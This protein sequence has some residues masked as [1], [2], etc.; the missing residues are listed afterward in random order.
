METIGQRRL[1][2]FLS[3]Y[4]DLTLP[5]S[6]DPQK[7]SCSQVRKD[8]GVDVSDY[9]DLAQKVATVQYYNP[10]YVFLYRGQAED[11]RRKAA[12]TLKP[13]IFRSPRGHSPGSQDIPS[14][15]ELARRYGVLRQAERLLVL[16]YPHHDGRRR[17]RRQ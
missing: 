1:K 16:L 5:E 17:L 11:Y 4:D 13:P 10:D 3:R 6:D 9:L 15:D 12:S 7:V 14:G 2:S 8:A